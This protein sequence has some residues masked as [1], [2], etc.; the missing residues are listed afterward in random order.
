MLRI[1]EIAKRILRIN[2]KFE[3]S[4]AYW[5]NRYAN[6]GN[7]GAGSYG[8]FAEFKARTLNQFVAKESI[9]TVIEFG[10]GDGNQLSLATYPSYLGVD[11]SELAVTRCR[12][13]FSGDKTKHFV[14]MQQYRGERADVAM[15]LDVIYHLV[16]SDV[17]HEYMTTL[18]DSAIKWVVVYSSNFDGLDEA[19]AEHVLHRKFTD[20]VDANRPRWSLF[21]VVKNE[22]PFTGDY[23]TGS[24]ADFYFYESPEEM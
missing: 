20:W 22:L 2:P 13:K 19:M 21:N 12:K 24:H 10:C 6:G 5:I 15:S 3:G 1:I 9:E 17:F 14:T 7:S 4:S 16:E 23:R 11:V 8:A 18:F